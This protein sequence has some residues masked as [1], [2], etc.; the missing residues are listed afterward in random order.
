MKI[1]AEIGL[2]HLGSESIALEY[3]H[4]LLHTPIDGIS[5]QIREDS[6]YDEST[7]FQKK[8]SHNFY[9]DI[10][11][12]IKEENKEIGFAI[13]EE[14]EVD[15]FFSLK[16]NFWKTLS[17]DLDNISLQEK[18]SSTNILRYV[19]TGI[20]D[21][22][23]LLDFASRNSNFEFI[24]TSL[25]DKMADQNLRCIKSIFDNSKIKTAF[26]LHC[27]LE[28]AAYVSVSF[29]PSAILFYVKLDSNR[30]FPDSGH[31]IDIE[32]LDSFLNNIQISKELLGSG[33]KDKKPYSL[34]GQVV[35]SWVA[36]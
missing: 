12:T 1:I 24:H 32:K 15:N 16:P 5:F 13:A 36:K 21:M 10:S 9:S 6:F 30:H 23:A 18:L 11:K 19:S 22:N 28:L 31:A 33:T 2:N 29:N 34:K 20:S 17:W 14:D 27:T 3:V 35:P 26:G 4:A 7:S 25:S 8:L